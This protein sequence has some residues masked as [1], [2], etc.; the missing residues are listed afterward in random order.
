MRTNATTSRSGPAAGAVCVRPGRLLVALAMVLLLGSVPGVA[1]EVCDESAGTLGIQGLRCEG[2]TYSMSESGIQEARFRTEP[3]ILA[4][5]RGF[6]EGDRLRAGDRIVAIDGA[7]IT[8]RE[9]S[10]RLVDLRAGQA[11]T[12]RVRRDGRIQDLRMVAGSACELV[13]RVRN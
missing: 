13:R 1:Q 5:V 4:V 8:T 11:V 9:G 6:T 2:C 10:D 12:V 3:Q 7:L